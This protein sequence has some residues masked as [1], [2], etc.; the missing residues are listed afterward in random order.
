MAIAPEIRVI[1]DRVAETGGELDG[2]TGAELLKWMTDLGKEMGTKLDGYADAITYAELE[3]G[4]AKVEGDRYQIEANLFYDRMKTLEALVKHLKSTA[5][6]FMILTEQ[7]LI[8]TAK[9]RKF[10]IQANGGPD[11]LDPDTA[12][13]DDPELAS[14]VRTQT[15]HTLDESAIV[16]AIKGGRTF[17]NARIRVKGSHL[18]ID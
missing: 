5:R 11:V 18:R 13:L 8:E 2:P 6:D 10:R 3:A 17:T 16:Q 4:C 14:F 1:M 12:K 9:N 7:P 15:I